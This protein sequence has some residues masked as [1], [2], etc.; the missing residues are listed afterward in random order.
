MN[1]VDLT[2]SVY[3]VMPCGTLW[4]YE[5]PVTI[6]SPLTWEK[7]GLRLNNLTMFCEPGT[8]LVMPSLAASRAS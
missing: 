8:R 4:P 3:D 6:E 5:R 2:M 1:I 7:H